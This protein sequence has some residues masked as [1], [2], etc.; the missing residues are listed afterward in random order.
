MRSA[1]DIKDRA[2]SLVCAT[3]ATKN[4]QPVPANRSKSPSFIYRRAT[5]STKHRSVKFLDGV[6]ALRGWDGTMIALS[7]SVSTSSEARVA[8]KAVVCLV[9]ACGSA[10]FLLQTPDGV[11]ANGALLAQSIGALDRSGGI[12]NVRLLLATTSHA[13]LTIDKYNENRQSQHSPAGAG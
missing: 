11:H 12:R 7:A 2:A 13:V 1:C 6:Q 10:P 3:S 5:K 4:T 8:S 9:E